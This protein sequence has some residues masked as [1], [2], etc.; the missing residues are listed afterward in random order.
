[1]VAGSFQF[2]LFRLDPVDRLLTHDGVQVELNARYL[3]AL[4][5]LVSEQ[6]RLVSK[7]R[8]LDEVW[9]G[10]PV[11]DEALT[12]CVRTIRRQLGDAA[13]QPRFIETIPKHG[14]R[15]IAP[16]TWVEADTAGPV[17]TQARFETAETVPL[18]ASRRWLWLGGAGML[19]GG[20]VG[21]VGGLFYGFL[22]AAP[23]L[24]TGMGATSIVLVLAS[25]TA[26]IG[27]IGGGGVAFG[28]AASS[29]APRH[30]AAWGVIGGSLGGLIVGGLVELLGLDAFE[31][32]L[33]RSPGDIT[34]AVEGAILG[35]A[36][37]LAAWL[38][39]RG[40]GRVKLRRAVALAAI[41]GGV[42]G[43]II[44]AVGG[45]MLGGSLDALAQRFSG[46]RLQLDAIGAL[47]GESEFGPLS[48]M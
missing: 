40:A 4:V 22:G 2:D 47:F 30:Q 44:S 13:G 10:V 25:L 36:V 17:S 38:A 15:F 9:R 3:D 42:A 28:Y 23:A 18:S 39:G 31:L 14:Y 34:G 43:V 29:F 37:S 7:T 32:L 46:S 20:F 27:L 16:V 48:R 12:Q 35:G 5:L 41:A 21:I 6:G 26:L 19:G 1:M 45:L 33:G 11:T 8:F 24:Q